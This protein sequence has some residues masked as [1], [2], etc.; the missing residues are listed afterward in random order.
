MET[1]T[2]EVAAK[3]VI[4]ISKGSTEI[5]HFFKDQ[6]WVIKTDLNWIW[7]PTS[8]S[9]VVGLQVFHEFLP[10]FVGRQFALFDNLTV[11]LLGCGLIE[12]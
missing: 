6:S 3:E 1:L 9:L 12:H 5:A 10:L 8:V 11:N 4:L 7:I 2:A